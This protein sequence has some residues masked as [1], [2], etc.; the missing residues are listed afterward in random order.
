MPTYRIRSGA[1]GACAIAASFARRLTGRST[2]SHAAQPK[3]SAHEMC[4]R[5]RANT[6]HME[7]KYSLESAVLQVHMCSALVQPLHMNARAS[8]LNALGETV[9]GR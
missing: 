4:F 2:E 6:K 5:A 3:V 9:E 1:A 7:H 8:T